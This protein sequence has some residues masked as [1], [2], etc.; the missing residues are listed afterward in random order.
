MTHG[1]LRQHE[2]Q[3]IEWKRDRLEDHVVW[4]LGPQRG[5]QEF[6]QDIK[7]GHLIA[8]EQGRFRLS[9]A[10]AP[11]MTAISP[12][13]TCTATNAKKSGASEGRGKPAIVV[14]CPIIACRRLGFS[15]FKI[16]H[17]LKPLGQFRGLRSQISFVIVKIRF[18]GDDTN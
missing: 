11:V 14:G 9:T 3:G 7:G 16:F 13:A 12:A 8:Q 4:Q 6:P 1:S 15:S 18:F 2:D 5:G 17:S 10:I